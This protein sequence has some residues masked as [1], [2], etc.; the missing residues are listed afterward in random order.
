MDKQVINNNFSKNA[1]SYDA[2]AS[3]QKR[4][5]EMLVESLGTSEFDRIL[6]IGCG[7]G[8]YTDRLRKKYPAAEI[9]ALDISERMVN[10]AKEKLSGHNI[11]F[12]RTDAEDLMGV[13]DVDLVTSNATLQWFSDLDA[14]FKRFSEIL[15]DKGKMAVTIYGPD[16]FKEF[17]TVLAEHYGAGQWLTSSKFLSKKELDTILGRHFSEYKVSDLSFTVYCDSLLD[18]LKDIKRTGTRG[19]GLGKDIFLGKY[20]LEDLEWIYVDKYGRIKVTH[21]V[22]FCEAAV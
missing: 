1:D 8:N 13:K 7:T 18:F 22:H 15:K 21:H 6:E 2:Y 20:G 12:M 11:S 17:K 14:S 16:T 9:M 3:V 10:I 4:C 5:A 19:E